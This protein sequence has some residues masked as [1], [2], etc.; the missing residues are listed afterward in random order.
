MRFLLF[1]TCVA[2]ILLAPVRAVAQPR[3]DFSG[4]W[5]FDATQTEVSGRVSWPAQLVITHTPDGVQIEGSSARQVPVTARYR[6][7]GSETIVPA[8]R[9]VTVRSRATW[10]GDRLTIAL[11][12]SFNTPTGDVTVTLTEV[13]SRTEDDLTVERQEGDGRAVKIVYHKSVAADR[14]V[15]ARP[16][17]LPRTATGPIPRTP[18]GKPDL[19]GY[20]T[21]RTRGATDDIEPH[22]ASYA[23]GAGEGAV[24]DPPDGRLPVHPWVPAAREYR[25]SRLYLDPEAHCFLSGLPRMMYNP[26]PFQII[27]FPDTIVMLFDSRHI[28][29]I[30]P[31]NS[32]AHPSDTIKLWMG[33]SFA[34]WEGDT[35]VI[36]SAKF[37]GKTW[38]DM[39]GNMT[40]DGLHVVER[41]WFIDANTIGYEATLT[42]P[43]V[44]TRPWTMAV[45]WVRNRDQGMEILE[46]AC[47]EGNLDVELLRRTTDAPP[48]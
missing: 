33:H 32:R 37:S 22:P 23:I 21:A 5:S 28:Y 8:A 1:A 40:S 29:R 19:Q 30:V 17:R 24:V 2:A 35:L 14:R 44:Y 9:G 20:W 13:Y 34:Y 45:T 47:H 25:A 12:R 10:T 15:A 43:K 4:T 11:R 38:L 6:F 39:A 31:M 46:G 7:D 27:F 18:D 41:I 36:D 3:P 16:P 26:M 42:D 48:Q